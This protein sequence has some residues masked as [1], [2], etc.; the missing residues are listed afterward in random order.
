[1]YIRD[2]FFLLALM[3]A[4][5][6]S[7]LLQRIAE[8]D[9]SAYRDL[10]EL[11]YDRLLRFA[12]LH[13]HSRELSEEIVSDVFIALWRRR[14]EALAIR[15]LR[16]YLYTAVKHTA[17]NYVRNMQRTATVS[18]DDVDPGMRQPFVNPEQAYVSK[19]MQQR[20]FRAIESLP[21]RCRMVFKL[22]KEDG[23]SY[24]EAA[25]LL[26]LSVSTI[27]NQ[28]VLAVRKISQSIFYHFSKDKKKS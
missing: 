23:L 8:N 1:M 13:T 3:N 21:P 20:I 14:Q 11:Y 5:N 17:L 18:L 19:E 28:L 25:S 12:E 16:L 7:V 27:D 2:R 4:M 15:S 22:V 6:D 26:N 9:A 10:F 24:K